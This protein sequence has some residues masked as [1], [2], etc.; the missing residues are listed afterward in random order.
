[1][2]Q[3]TMAKLKI[4]KLTMNKV[5]MAQL[6]NILWLNQSYINYYH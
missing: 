6:T 3:P 1:M 2:V 5:N 4:T